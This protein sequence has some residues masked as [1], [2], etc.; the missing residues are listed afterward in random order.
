MIE[1][2]QLFVC[3]GIPTFEILKTLTSDQQSARTEACGSNV[4]LITKTHRQHRSD[5]LYILYYLRHLG[6]T[7]I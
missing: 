3:T 5:L 4:A 7:V 2:N 1:K 6:G